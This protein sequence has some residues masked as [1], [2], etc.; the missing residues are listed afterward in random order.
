MGEGSAMMTVRFID[1][2]TREDVTHPLD[3]T[4]VPR[5]GDRVILPVEHRAGD[6]GSWIVRDE[7]T[8][9][10]MSTHHTAVT[11]FVEFTGQ[12]FD[13]RYTTP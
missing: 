3:M 8:W 4:G 13:S 2:D 11:L 10:P 5:K 6:L 1:A 12:T 7:P 9:W